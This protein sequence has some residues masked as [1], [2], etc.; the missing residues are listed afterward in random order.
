MALFSTLTLE[1]LLPIFGEIIAAML[2]LWCVWLAAKNNV[3]NWPVAMVASVIY[4]Y[5]F[6]QNR[7]YSE[8]Y[9]QIVFFAFQTYG[10]WFWSELNPH[11][12]EK[13]IQHMPSRFRIII[14][15]V[16]LAVYII[17]LN[18]YL[19][20]YPDAQQPFIDAFL[21]VLSITALWMQARRWVENWYLWILADLFYVPMFFIGD[22]YVTSALYAVFVVLATKG[23][24]M[25]RKEMT[26]QK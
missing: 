11:K 1:T 18:V 23:F 17:W 21:T 10:W 6:Y 4:A 3:M 19:Y 26:L 12:S 8:T 15:I 14:P 16:F 5:V 7:F 22:Q 13:T 9:L 25:W 24:M 20:F 2:S